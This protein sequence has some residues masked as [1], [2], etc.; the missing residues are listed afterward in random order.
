MRRNRVAGVVT[1]WRPERVTMLKISKLTDY[2][3]VIM[4]HLGRAPEQVH[5]A[6]DVSR[7]T[8][9]ALPT[10]S[11]ILKILA[12]HAL[13]H[14]A[15]G[16]KGGYRVAREP[17]R[18][19]VADIIRAIEG[20]VSLTDCSSAQGQGCEQEPYCSIASNWKRINQTVLEALQGLSLQD[21]CAGDCGATVPSDLDADPRQIFSRA[22][23]AAPNA[24]LRHEAHG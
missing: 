11:K 13:V 24:V 15:R 3:T 2:G 1:A 10:V 20:P 4:A 5:S 8:R 6:A 19:S 12:N 16:A 21:M 17:Q 9:I 14:S 23:V 7:H 18:I 22:N